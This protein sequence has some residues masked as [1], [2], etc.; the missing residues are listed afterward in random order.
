[1]Y[2]ILP[3]VAVVKKIPGFDRNYQTDNY[4]NSENQPSIDFPPTILAANPVRTYPRLHCRLRV[5]KKKEELTHSHLQSKK[6]QNS[7]FNKNP[8]RTLI[9]LQMK[10]KS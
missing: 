4:D 1:M 5:T 2:I 9:I 3:H 10:G 6:L 8:E 7:R